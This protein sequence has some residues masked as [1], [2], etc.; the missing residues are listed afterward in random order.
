MLLQGFLDNVLFAFIQLRA[1]IHF[2]NTRL[3][4]RKETLVP[5]ISQAM[6]RSRWED[7][8]RH[9]HFADNSERTDSSSKDFKFCPLIKKYDKLFNI[10]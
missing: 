3:Y 1:L 8:K 7:I 9:L 6:T 4:W 5:Q 10:F 2:S